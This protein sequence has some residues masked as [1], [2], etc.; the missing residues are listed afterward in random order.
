MKRTD[1][2]STQLRQEAEEQIAHLPKAKLKPPPTEDLLHELQVHQIELE[3]QNEELRR[4][5]V[6]LENSRDRYVYFYDFAPI[7]YLTL[8]HEDMIDEINLTG[9][10]LLGMERSKLLQQRFAS[11]VAAKDVDRW[12][13]HFM[14]VLARDDTLTCELALRHYGGPHF[15]AQLDCR[16][17]KNDTQE[18]VVRIVLTDITERKRVEEALREQ[19]QFFRMITENI[20]D[21]IAVLDLEGRRLY[22][23]PSYARLF[24]DTEAMKGTDSFAEIHPDDRERL[25]RIFKETVQSGIGHRTEFRFVLAN[26]DIRY[27]ESCGGLIKNSRGKASCVLVVSHDI[28]ARKQAEDEIHNLAFYDELTRLPNRRLLNDRLEHTMAASKRSRLYAALMFLDL[29]NFK[30]L[31]DKHGHDVGDLLLIEVANRLTGCVREV[32]TVTRFGGDEFVVMLSELDEDKAKSAAQASIVAEKIR[33]A[34]AEPYVLKI[35]HEGQAE[36]TVEHRCTSSI[37]VVLFIHH[38]ASSDDI[39]KWA[40]MAMYEAKE[41]GGNQIRFYATNT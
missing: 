2:K 37:G 18:P 14:S 23:S 20:D 9:A 7:G 36:R 31:N 40:D 35:Q 8:N 38:E 34:L 30:P 28:T 27:M 22:N 11:F 25:E 1:K 15:Y 17:L 10:A 24:G 21:F 3:M 13:R 26:G 16:R 19:E 12:S 39:I 32:D 4:A 33:A 29:D 5:Q 6:E 41:A